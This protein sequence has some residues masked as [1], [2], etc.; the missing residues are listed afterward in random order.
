MVGN[1]RGI[2]GEGERERERGLYL[3]YNAQR[4]SSLKYVVL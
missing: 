3:F 1:F 4:K 2:C